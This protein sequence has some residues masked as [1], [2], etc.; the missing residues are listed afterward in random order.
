MPVRR[1]R[2]PYR[3]SSLAFCLLCRCE[4]LALSFQ[5]LSNWC[6]RFAKAVVVVVS[7][8]VHGVPRVL[9]RSQ[10]VAV[11]SLKVS[12]RPP[13]VD[14]VGRV[15]CDS[16]PTL[17]VV[18]GVRSASTTPYST[19]LRPWYMSMKESRSSVMPMRRARTRPS[20]VTGVCRST[21]PRR[22]F[23]E[24]SASDALPANTLLSACLRTRFTEA[25]G[26]PAPVSSPVEPRTT[27]MRSYST[28]SLVEAPKKSVVTVVGTPSY[29]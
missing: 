13:Q 29:W 9:E 17:S 22:R 25:D 21:V 4:P 6:V 18:F 12:G 23:H 2:S 11:P 24:P 20:F 8:W 1:S 3:Y 26:L 10:R 27:S 16:M 19:C 5:P 7:Q 15:A 14:E 28:G